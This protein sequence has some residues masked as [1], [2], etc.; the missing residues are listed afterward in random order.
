MTNQEA[1]IHQLEGALQSAV[2][3]LEHAERVSAHW[4]REYQSEA[5]RAEEL[6]QE[7]VALRQEMAELDSL[8]MLGVDLGR[9]WVEE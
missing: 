7:L 8:P 4:L 6:R 5:R 3:Q 9:E 1:R 2:Q